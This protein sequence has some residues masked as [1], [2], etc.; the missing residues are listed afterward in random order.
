MLVI[1]AVV[2]YVHV[3]CGLPCCLFDHCVGS[4]ATSMVYRLPTYVTSIW[5]CFSTYQCFSHGRLDIDILPLCV[6]GLHCYKT[7]C[8]NSIL[9]KNCCKRFVLKYEITQLRVLDLYCKWLMSME[10]D[11]KIPASWQL[12][13]RL[14]TGGKK[15][16]NDCSSHRCT[17]RQ[18]Q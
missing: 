15:L 3:H 2:R 1:L 17:T 12:V 7:Q 9:C 18:Q 14:W 6:S 10:P 8:Q 4:N 13:R 16:D 11:G 5:N